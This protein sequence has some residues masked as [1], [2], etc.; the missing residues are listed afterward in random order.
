MEEWR[1]V[2]R[3]PARKRAEVLG[4]TLAA[5]RAK[6]SPGHP[7]LIVV[8]RRLVL[9]AAAV[10]VR[11]S[12]RLACGREETT[13]VGLLSLPAAAHA[14]GDGG[15]GSEPCRAGSSGGAEVDHLVVEGTDAP[16]SAVAHRCALVTP[17]RGCTAAVPSGR[18]AQDFLELP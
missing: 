4:Q 17:A 5:K 13:K 6:M 14:V 1:A 2:L 18:Q 15:A 12:L 9:E 8:P 11:S 7:P 10:L 16:A 3:G